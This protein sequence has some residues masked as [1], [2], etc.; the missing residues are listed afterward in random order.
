MTIQQKEEYLGVGGGARMPLEAV[1]RK[2]TALTSRLKFSRSPLSGA[3]QPCLH[4]L[5]LFGYQTPVLDA[6]SFLRDSSF[7]TA[8]LPAARICNGS[9]Q[10]VRKRHGQS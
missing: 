4:G 6:A 7:F 2:Y 9:Q 8:S 3:A 1:L 10:S 5:W